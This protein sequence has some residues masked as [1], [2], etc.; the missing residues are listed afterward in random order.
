MAEGSESEVQFIADNEIMD[1]LKAE[2]SSVSPEHQELVEDFAHEVSEFILRRYDAHIT[3]ETRERVQN[4]SER[5][6]ILDEDSFVAFQ[7]VWA[8]RENG[9]QASGVHVSVGDLI[10]ING[11]ET[12]VEDLAKHYV[13]SNPNLGEK[14]AREHAL[15]TLVIPSLVHE[16]V[17]GHQDI[18]ARIPKDNYMDYFSHMAF[19]EC[20]VSFI[21]SEILSGDEFHPL[22]DEKK[23][24]FFKSLEDKYGERVYNVLFGNIAD[25]DEKSHLRLESKILSEFTVDDIFE[26]GIVKRE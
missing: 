22:Q 5:V 25:G 14:N 6:V 10:V 1:S 4:F 2:A 23:V 20:G 15:F 13:K 26:L 8:L 3:D 7:E 19:V 16:T 24:D 18:S 9:V 11:R 12:E 21:T 17:H